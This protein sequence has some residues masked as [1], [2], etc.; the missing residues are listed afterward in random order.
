MKMP[1][2]L[3]RLLPSRSVQ[4]NDLKEI[5]ASIL[6]DPSLSPTDKLTV[7]FLQFHRSSMRERHEDIAWKRRRN[8]AL[9]V[10]ALAGTVVS[11][12]YNA[13][14][15][16]KSVVPYDHV[17]VV[18][19]AGAIGDTATAK[20]GPINA[21]LKTAF[22]NPRVK[23]IIL[24]INSPGGMPNESE[25]IINEIGRLKAKHN[26]P[27]DAVI[28]N[29]GA[30]AAYMIAVHA[31]TVYAGRYSLVGSVGAIIDSWNFAKIADKVEAQRMTFVSGKFKDLLNPYRAIREEERAKVQSMVDSLGA[32]FAGEV[33]ARRQGK[34]KLT[35]QELATGEVWAGAD[36]VK[37]G[38]VDKIGT[39]ADVA[40]EHGLE[41]KDMGPAEE[42]GFFVPFT[43]S[44]LENMGASLSRGALSVLPSPTGIA[45]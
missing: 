21:A 7:A 11:V 10:F 25:A 34:L 40:H 8:I 37:L 17:A 26:K 38:L 42:R 24:R 28:E 5:D 39:V 18:N 6:D 44:M 22:E 1:S 30:S 36:A 16:T 35:Q 9:I 33:L 13:D 19:I 2:F 23:R 45:Q 43:S 4:E 29:V 12:V 31:D 14:R 27:V 3:K 41:A 32:V 20:R 15:I